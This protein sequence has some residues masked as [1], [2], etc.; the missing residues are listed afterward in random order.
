MVCVEP[1]EFAFPLS[2]G[3][4]F[5]ADDLPLFIVVRQLDGACVTANILKVSLTDPIPTYAYLLIC[6]C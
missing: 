4:S 6:L 2:T 1:S 5:C 3:L